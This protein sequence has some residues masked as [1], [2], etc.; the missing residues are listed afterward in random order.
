MKHIQTTAL[1]SFG[2]INIDQYPLV[3]SDESPVGSGINPRQGM[4]WGDSG[5]GNKHVPSKHPPKKHEL[6]KQEH[7]N[8]TRSDIIL[9]KTINNTYIHIYIHIYVYIICINM[10]NILV[11]N[12]QFRLAH[13]L[14]CPISNLLRF[15]PHSPLGPLGVP[16]ST[17]AWSVPWLRQS[18]RWLFFGQKN[19]DVRQCFILF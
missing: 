16:N 18:I 15:Y 8:D 17:A 13:F 14:W 19:R 7:F 4:S 3:V 1:F 10:Y 5:S 6:A 9:I 11:Q 12:P 2:R